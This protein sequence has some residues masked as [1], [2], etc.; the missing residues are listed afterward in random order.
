MLD[1]ELYQQPL[2]HG[3]DGLD[4]FFEWDVEVCPSLGD[5]NQPEVFDLNRAVGGFGPHHL[6]GF[7]R[8]LELLE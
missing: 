2:A 6:Q 3:V 4:G 1:G 8:E 5:N 7:G